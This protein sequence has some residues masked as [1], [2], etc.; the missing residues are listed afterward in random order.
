MASR[1]RSPLGAPGCSATILVPHGNS[2][3]KN[4]AMESFGAELVVHGRDFDEAKAYAA[5]LAAE[6]GLHFVPS[7]DRAAGQGRRHLRAGAFPR[8]ARPRRGLRADRHGLRHLRP[9]RGARPAG[10]R[11]RDR[12]RG[13]GSGAGGGAVVRG[14][15]SGAHQF[16]ADVRRRHGLP[17]A[18]RRGARHHRARA[19][20]AW[21]ASTEDEI[22]EAIR[23][24]W[25]A[26]HNVAEGAGAAP[27][28]ALLKERERM[29]GKRVGLILSGGN[30]DTRC[31]RPCSRAD[32]RGVSRQP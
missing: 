20:R 17:R 29:G 32:T 7:F 14:G 21:C 25:T 27:L 18:A 12:R 4:A 2:V 16:G 28:A 31:L 26:T 30:I 15:P 5:R 23:L 6:R 9:D 13:R 19:R 10:P 8:R 11:D 3:E 1:S 24:Y 22:A